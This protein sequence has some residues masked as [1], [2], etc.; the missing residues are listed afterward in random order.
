M[1]KTKN[2]Q[3]MKVVMVWAIN[4]CFLDFLKTSVDFLSKY[5][6]ITNQMLQFYGVIR[7]V[8]NSLH[9]NYKLGTYNFK[10]LANIL[11]HI[12]EWAKKSVFYSDPFTLLEQNLNKTHR[13]IY[14]HYFQSCYDRRLGWNILWKSIH[15]F[16]N[17]H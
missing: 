7:L 14:C 10:V 17:L 3:K 11:R 5:S 8:I 16:N 12:L 6:Q 2:R 9:Y 4:F 15:T 13:P 1:L